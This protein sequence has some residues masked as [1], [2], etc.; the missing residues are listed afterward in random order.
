M[1]AMKKYWY[2]LLSSVALQVFAFIPESFCQVEN[3]GRVTVFK[4][5]DTDK[6]L[7]ELIPVF[8]GK[9]LKLTNQYYI[10]AHGD[11]LYID[12]FRFYMANISF[13]GH[14]NALNTNSHLYDAADSDTYA[15]I[16]KNIP[17]GAYS[18]LQFTLGVDN[19]ANTS[20]AN[21]G[22]LDPA[23]G[24]YWAWNSGYIMAKLE[25]RS[26]V[27]KTLHHAFQFHIGGYM[28]PYNA[29]R[30]VTLK[31]PASFTIGRSGIPCISLKVDVAAW[32]S[33]DFDLAKVNDIAVPGKEA[34]M[35]AD[36][37]AKMFSID[38][39][40]FLRCSTQ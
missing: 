14:R 23:K 8:N 4:N 38:G 35:M 5:S 33:G 24:M 34:A 17:P 6:V 9:P 19:I 40:E 27:C 13:T 12:A 26:K 1:T 20:G 32:F 11:T 18:N 25:G 21:G 29:A 39:V 3:L 2:I 37:Y 22:D 15:F 16:I 31:L 7:I 30:V 36:K 10:N 28:P